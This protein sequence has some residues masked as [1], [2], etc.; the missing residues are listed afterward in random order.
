MAPWPCSLRIANYDD[1]AIGF[2]M[3]APIIGP[4]GR[5]FIFGFLS[6][7]A[8]LSIDIYLPA[9]P[10]LRQAL[11][12][13]EAQTLF[14]LS[15][16]FIGFGAGQLLLGPLSDR[17]GR[18]SP[19]L[20]G[21]VLYVIASA[22]CAV[23]TTMSAIVFWRFVQAFG[24]SVVPMA[25]QAMVRDLYDRNQSAR[26]LSLNLMVTASAPV[27]APLIGGQ[28]LLW[29]D[30]RAI[31]W[32]LAGFGILAFLA[33]L[34]LPE[35]LDA[36]R[37]NQARPLAMLL[38][39]F[40]LFGNRRY[41][42]YVACSTFYFFCLFGFIAGSPFVYIEYYG[43]PPQYYG[44]LFGVNMIGMITATFVNSRIVLR[45]GADSLLRTACTIG[46]AGS[47]VLLATGV[48]GFGGIAGIALPLF[49][50]LSLLTIVAP[51][52]ISGALAVSPN[53]AGAAAAMAGALQFGGGA[54]TSAAVGWL[55]DGTPRPMSVIICA[56]AVAALAANLLLLGRPRD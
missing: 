21:L 40:A 28:V 39:Y 20:T 17:F 50:V 49:V 36:S 23:A 29:L 14:T 33:A 9:L 5:I 11:A 56:G 34:L 3:P 54:L 45:R 30:W 31:F 24:G 26:V 2:E 48:S 27:I 38:G 41:V 15:A 35:T 43:V 6:A 18:K 12:A 32:V 10:M 19:L 47:L 46:C 4:R 1:R 53:R 7:I 37:R 55:A 22:A 16:F 42:G 8:P 51:N 52:A 25:V 44:F 13:N